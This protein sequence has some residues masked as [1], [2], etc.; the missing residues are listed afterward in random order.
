MEP[1][2]P[3]AQ[4]KD[5]HLPEPVGIWPL[6][7]GWWLLLAVIIAA[8]ALVFFFWRRHSA[9]N[10]YRAA[11]LAELE[12]E[13]NRF[14]QS[15]NTADYLQQAS[16]ILRR[17]AMSGSG[18]NYSASLKGEAWLQWLD[19][20]WTNNPTPFSQG[21]GRALLTG[22]YEKMPE[23]NIED[24]HSL[25]SQWLHHHR[26][27]WQQTG[28]DKKNLAQKKPNAQKSDKTKPEATHHA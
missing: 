26:N 28:R 21:V 4:L 11:A 12:R 17:A 22:P 3:L 10:R 1:M 15:Q 9:R 18:R 19:Q 8:V 13:K 2:D 5:I 7:W 23:A 14:D 24:L 6:A 16:V 25:I 27:Q 20:R